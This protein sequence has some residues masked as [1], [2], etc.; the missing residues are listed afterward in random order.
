MREPYIVATIDPHRLIARREPVTPD[1]IAEH[2]AGLGFDFDRPI[3]R[4]E[5]QITGKVM[6]KQA[7][8][9]HHDPVRCAPAHE[10]LRL[11]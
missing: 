9:D 6:F 10:A 2:L 7:I 1:E 3:I 5:C 11:E 8:A 4:Q